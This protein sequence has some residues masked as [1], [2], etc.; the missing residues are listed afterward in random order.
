MKDLDLATL[1]AVFQEML[2]WSFWAILAGSVV[3][4][5]AFAFVL[6]RDRG[7]VAARLVRAEVAGVLGGVAA[8]AAMF[9]VT[10]SSAADMGGPVDWLLAVG[11]FAGGLVGG[12]IA[13]YAVMGLFATQRAPAAGRSVRTVEA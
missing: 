3:A 9:M 12:T 2:G 1:V 8:V 4:T 5:L 10:N 6:V 11:I 7:V 13:A